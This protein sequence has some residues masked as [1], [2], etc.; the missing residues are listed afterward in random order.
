MPRE[1]GL[2]GDDEMD[3][4]QDRVAPDCRG[5]NF[6]DIDPD[7]DALSTLYLPANLCT[8]FQRM[9]EIAGEGG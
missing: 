9:G 3:S 8:H 5:A 6:Y 4:I 2:I 1:T 7:I